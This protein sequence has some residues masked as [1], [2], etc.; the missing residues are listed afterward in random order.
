[1]LDALAPGHAGKDRVLLPLLISGNQAPDRLP[2]HLTSR[3]AEHALGRF[4]PTRDGTIER[5][6]DNRIGR[7]CHDG[8]KTRLRLLGILAYGD[9]AYDPDGSDRHPRGIR[10]QPALILQ[11]T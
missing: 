4:I 5:L 7:R 2:N 11:P 8:S 3:I 1:M 6:A 10:F 9:I